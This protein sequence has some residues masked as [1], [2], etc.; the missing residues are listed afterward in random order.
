[1]PLL[2]CSRAKPAHRNETKADRAKACQG[3]RGWFS[4]KFGFRP[5]LAAASV[6]RLPRSTGEHH[7]AGLA[8]QPAEIMGSQLDEVVFAGPAQETVGP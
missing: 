1:M 5:G 2:N 8:A 4:T 6:F 7:I 3:I